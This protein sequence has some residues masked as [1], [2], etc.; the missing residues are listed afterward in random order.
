MTYNILDCFNKFVFIYLVSG[1]C[2]CNVCDTSDPMSFSR[3][4]LYIRIHIFLYSHNFCSG[5][6]DVVVRNLSHI[7]R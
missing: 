3:S 6:V 4:L 5:A 1:N 7:T 2:L